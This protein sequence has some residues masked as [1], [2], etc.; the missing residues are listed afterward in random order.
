MTMPTFLRSQSDG[1]PLF[2]ATRNMSQTTIPRFLLPHGRQYLHRSSTF[3]VLR[4][5]SHAS[6]RHASASSKPR[7][8][9]K[10]SKFNPPSHPSRLRSKPRV[11]P[12]PPL[13]EQQKQ[14]QKTKQYPH[15]MPP[16]G[17]FMNWF[18]RERSI[19]VWISMVR[20]GRVLT[21]SRYTDC[22]STGRA[23]LS[24][25]LRLHYGLPR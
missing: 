12:G 21:P 23:F 4:L 3:Q 6:R 19:H 2:T 14:D 16:E 17:T 1:K 11:Y 24:C 25:F 15:M 13:S 9:E 22:H 20:L 8:L 18:L 10:P 5:N 7:V